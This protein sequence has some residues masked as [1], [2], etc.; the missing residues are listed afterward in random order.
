MLRTGRQFWI[1]FLRRG[2]P[3][4][5]RLGDHRKMRPSLT[6]WIALLGLSLA[7]CQQSAIETVKDM[8]ARACGA[9]P[10]GFFSRVD[11]TAIIESY[12]RR[13]KASEEEAAA[14]LDPLQAVAYRRGFESRI[15][16]LKNVIQEMFTKWEDEIKRGEASDFC[17]MSVMEAREVEN[18]ADV[19]VRTP[20]G[21]DKVWRLSRFG[22]RWLLVDVSG[23]QK[24]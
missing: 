7:G 15:G 13:A 23:R 2:L 11:R 6:K 10:A 16:G 8:R 19:Y 18:S 9:D 12:E 24:K 3:Y 21:N 14:K 5:P 17:R 1:Q 4:G 20:S 22:K